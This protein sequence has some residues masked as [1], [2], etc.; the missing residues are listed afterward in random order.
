MQT[1]QCECARRTENLGI[2]LRVNLLCR[3]ARDGAHEE[4]GQLQRR[5]HERGAHL[6]LL[7]CRQS[8]LRTLLLSV[9]DHCA[10]CG[11]FVGQKFVAFFGGASVEEPVLRDLGMATVVCARVSAAAALCARAVF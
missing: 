4:Q 10:L 6:G 11:G 3:R 7:L 8:A 2:N 9:S 1:L 5:E